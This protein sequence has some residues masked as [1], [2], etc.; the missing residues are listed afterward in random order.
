MDISGKGPGPEYAYRI[1]YFNGIRVAEGQHLERQ[2]LFANA[3]PGDKVLIAIKL[4]ATEYEKNLENA[5]L[6]IEVAQGRPNPKDLRAELLSAAVLLPSILTDPTSLAAQEAIL[7]AAARSINIAA[8][9]KSDQSGFDAS[10]RAAQSALEPL[11]PILQRYLVHMT[12]NAHI[13]AA[14]LWT[15]T[16]T[17]DQVHFTFANALRMMNEYPDY[18]FAQSTAQYSE[19]MA[20]KFPNLFQEIQQR[21]KQGRWELVGGMW[22]E[23]DLN[24]TDGESEVRQLLVGT[25]YLRSKFGVDVHVGWNPDSFGYNWQLPQ[26]Y[27]KSGIDYFLTQKLTENETNPIPLKL[28]WWRAPDGSRVLTYIPHDYVIGIDPIDLAADLALAA[29]MNPGQDELLHLFGPS[30]GR[31]AVGTAREDIDS[32]VHWA[33]TRSSLSDA[34]NLGL[35]SPSSKRLRTRSQQ[36]HRYGPIARSRVKAPHSRRPLPARSRFRPGMTS[37][38]LSIIAGPTRRRRS[39]RRTCGRAK[40]GC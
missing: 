28:F 19:W 3:K 22:V 20:E 15:S 6:T 35:R 25:G 1:V 9:D 2:L 37:S 13:D 23:P 12:G 31:L 18:T 5:H 34:W 11:R 16:E 30:F 10:L 4:L 8:L 21:V 27:K 36:N 40:S 7:D 14:W 38:I 39:R 17:V 32:G 24:M 33:A 29:K 26:I